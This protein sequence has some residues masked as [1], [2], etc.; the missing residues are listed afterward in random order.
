M[1]NRFLKLI[2]VLDMNRQVVYYF[3]RATDGAMGPREVAGDQ[4]ARAQG[5]DESSR[6]SF[7]Q[8]SKRWGSLVNCEE[9]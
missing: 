9:Q 5:Q 4:G 2:N 3:V 1:G 8:S 6:L 7:I